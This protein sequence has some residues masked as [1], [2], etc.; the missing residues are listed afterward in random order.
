MS[1]ISKNLGNI[2]NKLTE[3]GAPLIEQL[4]N[5]LTGKGALIKY[6]FEDLNIEMPSATDPKGRNRGGGRMTIHGTITISAKMHKIAN[7]NS[8]NGSGSGISNSGNSFKYE[9]SLTS[10][11]LGSDTTSS[12]TASINQTTSQHVNNTNN[13]PALRDYNSTENTATST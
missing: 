7:L 1:E 3:Q 10:D 8:S 5:K 13:E 4:L 6:S 12:T 9:R 11:T 2:T